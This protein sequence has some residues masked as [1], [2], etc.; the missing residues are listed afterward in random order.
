MHGNGCIVLIDNPNP[1]KGY[2]GSDVALPV[3]REIVKGLTFNDT[4]LVKASEINDF[5]FSD[6]KSSEY[7][8]L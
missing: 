7:K 8:K 1:E 3:F 6:T 4:I 5:T 2:Y